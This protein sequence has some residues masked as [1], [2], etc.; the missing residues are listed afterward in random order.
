ME[1]IANEFH[2]KAY[3]REFSFERFS[4]DF[5]WPAK[6]KVIE[7]DGGQ[8]QRFEE[9]R[10]R[11]ARKDQLLKENGWGVLRIAWK[12]FCG[13]TKSWINKANNFIGM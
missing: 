5:A 7:I 1:V 4:L 12:D 13:D 11:D 8:H 3:E 6:K 2:D 9:Y 10:L